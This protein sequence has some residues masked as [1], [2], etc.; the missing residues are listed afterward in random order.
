[1]NGLIT[2]EGQSL[3]LEDDMSFSG[4]P[5]VAGLVEVANMVLPV[6]EFDHTPDKGNPYVYRLKQAAKALGGKPI[7]PPGGEQG[8]VVTSDT[9][10]SQFY[11]EGWRTIGAGAHGARAYI[12]ED[13]IIEKGC[14]GV[15][16]E[17]IDTLI[18]ES[19][20]S[21]ERRSRKEEAATGKKKSRATDFD[22]GANEEEESD[23]E[24][25][26]KVLSAILG[27]LLAMRK[28]RAQE[29]NSILSELVA[30]F[31]AAR[32]D[33]GKGST[34]DKQRAGRISQFFRAMRKAEDPTQVP[35][36]DEML[37]MVRR[38]RRYSIL[39]GRGTA[40]ESE[41]ADDEE[42]ALFEALKRGRMTVPSR[43]DERI[44]A[45]AHDVMRTM[46]ARYK[47]DPELETLPFSEAYAE[48]KDDVLPQ[49]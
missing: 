7:F 36:F 47:S 3:Y 4:P 32:S 6:E 23:E 31:T 12:N 40:G 24:E 34:K 14:E 9:E 15:K 43:N 5:K 19:D 30:Q 11:E 18:D 27:D 33:L 41:G 48:V 20:A 16:G 21:R 45:E 8:E 37:E 28:K 17:H 13:G 46:K 29:Y 42:A 44:V 35:R 26:E 25:D 2:I 22:F 1:M 39:L 49:W 38:D 10:T